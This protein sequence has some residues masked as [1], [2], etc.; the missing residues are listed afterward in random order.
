MRTITNETK[1]YFERGVTYIANDQNAE[2]ERH[3]TVSDLLAGKVIEMV[4]ADGQSDSVIRLID[5]DEIQIIRGEVRTFSLR[6]WKDLL[7]LQGDDDEK[8]G[9]LR[10]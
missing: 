8:D 10:F 7:A 3:F 4:D 6:Q 9:F 5:G 1:L 2:S